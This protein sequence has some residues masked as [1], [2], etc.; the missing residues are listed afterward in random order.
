M[1]VSSELRREE[2]TGTRVEV[3]ICPFRAGVD[4]SAFRQLNEAWIERYFALEPRDVETLSDP[5]G[6]ILRRGGRVYM[7]YLGG[8]A[9]GCV[10]LIPMRAGVYELSKMA[11][12]PKVQ[13]RGIGRRLL[14]HAIA[15]ARVLGAASLFLGSNN[16]LR[17]AV[18]LYEAVGFKHVPPEALPPLAYSRANV[19]MEMAL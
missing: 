13:G 10:A 3:E 16:K 12:S 15:E 2:S 9:V 14:Q 7:A 1:L 19:F 4:E 8:E 18:H 6:T 5:E 11:V 17:E